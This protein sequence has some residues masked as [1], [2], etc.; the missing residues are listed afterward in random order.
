MNLQELPSE[1]LIVIFDFLHYSDKLNYR[2]INKQFNKLKLKFENFYLLLQINYEL[3]N[4]R[5][6][7]TPNKLES[8]VKKEE[9]RYKTADYVHVEI[10]VPNQI[11]EFDGFNAFSFCIK[12]NN[13][14]FY[15][16]AVDYAKDK[17]KTNINEIINRCY[18][19]CKEGK[20]ND[21]NK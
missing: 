12:N 3:H 20:Y 17:D 14:Y 21:T 6:F 4:H 11:I 9:K 7:I 10:L 1:L 15:H 13:M 2:L 16:P 5:Y 18:K 8:M 19:I